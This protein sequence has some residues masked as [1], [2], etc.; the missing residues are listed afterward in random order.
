MG[1]EALWNCFCVWH[2]EPF[3]DWYVQDWLWERQSG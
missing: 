1:A 2:S 3:E